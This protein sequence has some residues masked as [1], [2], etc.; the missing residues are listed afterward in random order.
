MPHCENITSFIN[1]SDNS[2]NLKENLFTISG[3]ET[4]EE[5]E[6]H[7]GDF[8]IYLDYDGSSSKHSICSIF[9][10]FS[11]YLIKDRF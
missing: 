5:A 9:Q 7:K 3:D 4:I 6:V 2:Q 8:P 10:P 1:S 11:S